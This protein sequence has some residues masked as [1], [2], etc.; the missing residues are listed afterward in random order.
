MRRFLLLFL[1]IIACHAISLASEQRVAVLEVFTNTSCH[2]CPPADSSLDLLTAD[3]AYMS[4]LAVIRYHIWWP[5]A[6]DPYYVYNRT[7]NTIRDDYYGNDY[8][9]H[10]FI[11]GNIDGGSLYENWQA[12]IDDELSQDAPISIS[13]SASFSRES[14][15]GWVSVK[16]IGEQDTDLTDLRLRLA[17]VESGISWRAPNGTSIHNQTLRL[18]IPDADGENMSLTHG[19]TVQYLF[20]YG[21]F[22]PAVPD[23]C[24]LIAFVQSNDTHRIFQGAKL[25]MKDLP[26]PCIVVSG[27][28]N[29][30]HMFNGVDIV[31]GVNYLKSRGM[32]PINSCDC[33]PG[34]ITYAAADA[35]G[36][37]A[38]NGIDICFGVNYLRGSGPAPRICPDCPVGR[39]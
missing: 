24:E 2:Y 23:S 14:D 30:D 19:D 25:S 36:D 39:P 37:C 4:K 22:Y 31:Y 3:S 21:L 5:S 12:E 29:G 13:L 17:V 35:N 26:E 15:S 9:P 18:M 8:T 10:G 32:A 28:A 1:L 16:I 27:D 6:S 20:A 11:D 38:F 7:A 34:R 33:E